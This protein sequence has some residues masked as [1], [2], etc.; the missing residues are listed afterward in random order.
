MQ[1]RAECCAVIAGRWRHVHFVEQPRAHQ[2]SVR[3]A[4]QSH[5]ACHRDFAE[6]C[7]G[8]KM[9]ADMENRAIQ[10]RLKRCRNIAMDLSDLVARLAPRDE[11]A[12]QPVARLQI[13]FALKPG[14]IQTQDWNSYCAVRT[15]LDHLMKNT[16]KLPRV[17]VRRESHDLVFVRIENE[18]EMIRH[19]R[20]ENPKRMV[21]RNSAQLFQSPAT[22]V[23]D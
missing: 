13:I 17:A 10:R 7:T 18:P 14:A 20:I 1:C 23:K 8:A 22:A 5:S 12:R 15:A 4:I 19:Q 21:G 6:P 9:A 11:G 3:A 2:L 16:F